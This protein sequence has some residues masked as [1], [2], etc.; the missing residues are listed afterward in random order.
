MRSTSR[1]LLC[2]CLFS[3]TYLT[4][5]NNTS[6]GQPFVLIRLDR[7]GTDYRV[8]NNHS[9]FGGVGSS[10]DAKCVYTLDKTQAAIITFS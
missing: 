4:T 1:H 2:L 9:T 7:N 6:S 3:Y 5:S 10:D 8:D